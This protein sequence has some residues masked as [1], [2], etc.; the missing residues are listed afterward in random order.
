MAWWCSQHFIACRVANISS[1]FESFMAIDEDKGD[2]HQRMW[3]K[4]LCAA[5]PF[6]V[7]SF[8]ACVHKLRGTVD[9]KSGAAARKASSGV[10]RISFCTHRKGEFSLIQRRLDSITSVKAMG[11]QLVWCATVADFQRE[12]SACSR[13][14]RTRS[15]KH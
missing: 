13:R 2:F 15:V 8:S 10:K 6:N 9:G 5:F 7:F 1:P 14:M 4:K 3:E 11:R 12:S